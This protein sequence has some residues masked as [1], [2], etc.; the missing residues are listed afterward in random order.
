[1][2][3]YL[4][5]KNDLTFKRVFG[6]HPHLCLSLLNN[7]LPFEGEQKIVSLEYLPAELVP[8]VPGQRNS[9]VDVRCKDGTGRQF[10]VEMQMFWTNQFTSRILLNASKAYVKQSEKGEEW[11]FNFL[12]PVYA[13]GL[14]N[15]TFD[16]SSPDYYHHYKIVNIKDTEKQIKGLEFVFV[17]LPKFKPGNSGDKKLHE[18]W[19]RF[20]TEIRKSTQDAPEELMREPDTKEALRYLEEGAY[21]EAEMFAYD[22]YWDY[23]RSEKAIHEGKKEEGREIGREEGREIGREEGRAEEREKSKAIIEALKAENKAEKEEL[24]AK[25]KAEKEALEAEKEALEAKSK[26]EKEALEAEKEALEAKR[27]VEMEAF[28]AAKK[29]LEAELAEY[30]RLK[31]KE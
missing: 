29:A 18:L 24:E 2:A 8:L 17:E 21:T 16:R 4:D 20:L 1:M 26:A 11:N 27:K 22:K 25:S 7:M 19:M 13:L 31:S 15:D 3:R 12:Q 5:P 30:K 10:I 14:I 9:M 28:E 23:I 6:D